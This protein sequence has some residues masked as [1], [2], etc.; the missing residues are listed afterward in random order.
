MT[1]P[2]EISVHTSI[3]DIPLSAA[4]IDAL[5]NGTT[6][7]VVVSM[8]SP[9]SQT[10]EQIFVKLLANAKLDVTLGARGIITEKL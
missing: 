5:Y 4:G 7:R 6:I 1:S 9:E 2:I 3:D 8:N 10:S